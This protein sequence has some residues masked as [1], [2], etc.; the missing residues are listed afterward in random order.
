MKKLLLLILISISLLLCSCGQ[1]TNYNESSDPT[2]LSSIETITTTTTSTT[3]T[4]T[5]TNQQT[6]STSIISE[7]TSPPKEVGIRWNVPFI[8]QNPELPT[9]CEITS[10]TMLMNFYGYDY[11]KEEMNQKF[12]D[13]SDNFFW[14]NGQLYGPNPQ[15]FFLGN[16]AFSSGYYGLQCF[17]GVWVDT[18]NK[19]FKE[20]KSQRYAYSL[21]GLTLSELEKFL[22]EGPILISASID[23]NPA[24]SQVLFKDFETGAAVTTYRNFHCVVLVGYD[25]E[26]YYINDPLGN[27]EKIEKSKLQKAYESTGSQNTIIGIEKL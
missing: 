8:N 20:N 7:E 1:T 4:V 9:G 10:I 26:S 25:E 15:K 27:F 18:L 16:P 17:S 22:S 3:E 14:K 2:N 6:T 13:K 23:M 19:A 12:L 21:N 5:T 11:S 24:C